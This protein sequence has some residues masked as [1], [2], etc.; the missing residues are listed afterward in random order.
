MVK[1]KFRDHVRSKTEIAMATEV[2]C[3]VLCDNILC[4]IQSISELGIQPEFLI[5]QQ[6][7]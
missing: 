3:K 4:L 6:A 1:A 5:E 7:T 2:Y